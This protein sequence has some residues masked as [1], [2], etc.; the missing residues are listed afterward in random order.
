MYS[1]SWCSACQQ[2]KAWMTAHRIAF[3]ERDIDATTDYA[4]QL[5]LLNPSMSIPTFDIDGDVLVGFNPIR[6]ALT[7]R[8]AVLRQ[9][10][11][12]GAP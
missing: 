5:R 8:R 2:A 9:R 4:K 1:A 7:L 10:A 11:G 6:L 12:G 3:E